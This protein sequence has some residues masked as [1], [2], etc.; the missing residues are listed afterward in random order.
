VPQFEFNDLIRLLVQ[1][2]LIIAVTRGLGL[3][4]R[5]I[6]QPL[7]IAEVIGGILLGPSFLGW[8]WPD[9]MAT[10]FPAASMP[11]L[12]LL[13]QLGL[14]LFMFLVGL[15]LD[16]ALL[17]GRARSS[18]I[19]S[20]TSI[21]FPFV[22]G[23][24]L[25][26]WL[27]DL[28]ATPGV[29]RLS[30]TLFLGIAMSITAF[31]VLARILTERNLFAS[32]VGTLA[33]TCAAVN[34]VTAWCVLAFVV[35]LSRAQALTQA[36]W[37]LGLAIVF[38]GG[39]FMLVRPLLRRLGAQHALREPSITLIAGSL[40]LMLVSS[41][42]TESIGIH[43]LFGAFLM[44]TIFPRGRLAEALMRRIETLTMVL[45]LPL[46]FAY[47]G[48]R[49]DIGLLAEPREWLMTGLIVLIATAGKF[50]GSTIAARASGLAWRESSAIGILMNTRGL[51]ELVA[52]NIGRELG[53][54]SP[55]MFTM[56]VL[57]AL[58]TT[59]A[60]SP[61]L[62]LVYSDRELARHGMAETS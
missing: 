15:E 9:A 41:A 53:V 44:G 57:M 18:V 5:R 28:Y 2:A 6:G 62:R 20:Q 46:F 31:P 25:A 42:I 45:L 17:K 56:L 38:V 22:L 43:A 59:F 48:L 14:L 27:Y 3:V 35:A 52:L 54:I 60:T 40:L 49:T 34:D 21:V 4:L 32:K 26:L 51:M 23:S 1:M 19:I 10:L 58:V 33:I 13:S 30:F 39:M 36:L 47:S 24:A 50:G 8:L 11:A 7:V 55:T 12:T 29:S 37:T 61:A 16:P